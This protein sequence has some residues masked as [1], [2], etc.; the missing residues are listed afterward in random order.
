MPP[1]SPW[2]SISLDFITDLPLSKSYD[3]ILTM[4]DHFTKITHFLLCLKTFTSQ[5]TINIVIREIFKYYVLPH[6]IIS[7]WWLQFISKFW[8]HL[9]KILKI[10]C[11]TLFELSHSN[12][13][14][15]WANKPNIRIISLMLYQLST[16]RLGRFLYLAKF[17]YNNFSHFSIGYTILCKNKISSLLDDSWISIYLLQPYYSGPFIVTKGHSS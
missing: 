2:K 11:K 13:W 17:P 8:Q 4:V 3:V 7:N 1:T 9:F 10:S 14:S 16:R 12:W 6:N 5:H 15:K